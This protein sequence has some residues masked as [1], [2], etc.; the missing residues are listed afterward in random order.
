M[1]V[2]IGTLIIQRQVKSNDNK[3]KGREGR[4]GKGPERHERGFSHEEGVNTRVWSSLVWSGGCGKDAHWSLDDVH[5]SLKVWGIS[6]LQGTSRFTERVY[7]EVTAAA[8]Q[9]SGARERAIGKR[10]T[11]MLLNA[12]TRSEGLAYLNHTLVDS[13]RTILA[14]IDQCEIDPQKLPTDIPASDLVQNE[15]RLS[16]ACDT[17]LKSMLDHKESMPASLR[18][19]CHFLKASIDEVQSGK[20]LQ[21][22]TDADQYD[23][24]EPSS[25]SLQPK[26]DAK[27]GGSSHKGSFEKLA[28]SGGGSS[29]KGKMSISTSFFQ[30]GGVSVGNGGN[31]KFRGRSVSSSMALLGTP[32]SEASSARLRSGSNSGG[33]S[34]PDSSPLKPK[35][36]STSVD[37]LADSFNSVSTGGTGGSASAAAG[38]DG[39]RLLGKIF[40]G[41]KRSSKNSTD[42]ASKNSSNNNVALNGSSSAINLPQPQFDSSQ[43]TSVTSA[44]TL[45]GSKPL[46]PSD[47]SAGIQNAPTDSMVFDEHLEGLVSAPLPPRPTYFGRRSSSMSLRGVIG[48]VPWALLQSPAAP[49]GPHQPTSSPHPNAKSRSSSETSQQ[50]PSIISKLQA[51][52][53]YSQPPLYLSPRSSAQEERLNEADDG[54]SDDSSSKTSELTMPSPTTMP[55]A[56]VTQASGILVDID[57]AS[58]TKA[59]DVMSD[60]ASVS[61]GTPSL[62]QVPGGSSAMGSTEGLNLSIRTPQSDQSRASVRASVAT[63]NVGTRSS[64]NLTVA[65]KV[66]GSVLF[67]RFLIPAI[68]SPEIYGLV[69]T[70]PPVQAQRGLVL[71]SKVLTA[72]CNDI[73]FGS[74]ESYLIPMNTFLKEHRDQMKEFLNFSS[75]KVDDVE[76]PPPTPL[77]SAKYTTTSRETL[78]SQSSLEKKQRSTLSASMPSLNSIPTA[79][80]TK[81]TPLSPSTPS[82]STSTSIHRPQSLDAIDTTGLFSYIAR[83]LSTIEKDLEDRLPTLSPSETSGIVKNFLEMKQVVEGSVYASSTNGAG[84]GVDREGERGGGFMA[85]VKRIKGLFH[86]K[87]SQSTDDIAAASSATLVSR[88]E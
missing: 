46:L 77:S 82:S 76:V 13:V 19:L 49:G 85:K 87:V 69:D 79:S 10:M 15:E 52:R 58:Q 28:E 39:T 81:K 68:T 37:N 21:E 40:G 57:S 67:L 55:L 56:I 66:V 61:V 72:L 60:T 38:A 63:A 42:G 23:I 53:P 27:S 30:G 54:A 9:G 16:K 26:G 62:L 29:G 31:P 74:K 70:R 24:D 32:K 14:Y 80:S 17:I 6:G 2:R 36:G 78:K 64:G 12:F 5:A 1:I 11:T 75:Q 48:S 73:E 8:E 47:S 59:S 7:H 35:Q 45:P 3:E 43:T 71:A 84:L 51:Q 18:R 22:D 33:A 65:E 20:E 34:L 50:R 4:E 83:S 86:G 88:S 25:H 44:S 41:W